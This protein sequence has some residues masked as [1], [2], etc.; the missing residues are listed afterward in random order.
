MIEFFI[1]LSFI[2]L[3]YNFFCNFYKIS[4]LLNTFDKPSKRKLQKYKVPSIGGVFFLVNFLFILITGYLLDIKLFYFSFGDT[5]QYSVFI[6]TFILFFILG[7]VDDKY[8]LSYKT[9]FIFSFL[10]LFFLVLIDRSLII[11]DLK[12]S[13]LEDP[14]LLGNFAT[15]LTILCILLFLNACNMIDGLN[16]LSMSYFFFIIIF[17]IFTKSI[18]FFF[19]LLIFYYV[20][21]IYLNYK[22]K[23]FLGDNGTLSISFLLSYFFIKSYN[24]NFITNVD[25]IFIIM[26]VPGIDMLRL[27]FER[28]YNKKNPFKPDNNHLHHLLLFKFKKKNIASFL[29]LFVLI[30]PYVLTFSKLSNFLVILITLIG[31]FII[32][33][34]LRINKKKR[35]EYFS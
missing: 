22:N 4:L 6:L 31:Y 23:I 12:F 11:D 13:F 14:L 10:F 20:F 16:L 32:F 17:F 2:I 26:S 30:F 29:M 15:P 21:F 3:N 28:L 33:I 19:I 9:K 7:F 24:N 34:F 1:S 25:I 8:N 35:D 18:S 5:L 27:F